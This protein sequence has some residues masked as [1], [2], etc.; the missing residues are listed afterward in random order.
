MPLHPEV[1]R[2]ALNSLPALRSF[3]PDPVHAGPRWELSQEHSR[4]PCRLLGHRREG[5]QLGW[6]WPGTHTPVPASL[7]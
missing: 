1:L 6:A 5:P 3:P 4:G 7:P 2:A